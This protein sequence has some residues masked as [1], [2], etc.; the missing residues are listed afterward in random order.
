M[1]A[2]LTTWITLLA[3]AVFLRGNRPL[4]TDS[5]TETDKLRFKVSQAKVFT[6][7]GHKG[8]H[9]SVLHLLM[10]YGGMF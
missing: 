3:E 4:G 9:V 10:F 8:S 6:I 2:K 5:H 1:T 7:S